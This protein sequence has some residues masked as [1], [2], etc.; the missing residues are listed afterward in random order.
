MLRNILCHIMLAAAT[1]A[2]AAD[3]TTYLTPSRG[4]A[5]VTTETALS[6]DPDLCY[7]L[8]PAETTTL[9]V[10]VGAYE[11]KPAWAGEDTKALRYRLVTEDPVG[12]LSNFF[13]LERD[14]QYVGLRNMVYNSSLFQTHDNAGYMYVLTYTEPE[15]SEWCRLTATRADGYWLFES[16]KYPIRSGNWACGYLGPWNRSVAAGE[17]IA[18]NRRNEAGDEAGRYRLF[19]ISHARLMALRSD[20]LSAATQRDFTGSIVNPSFESG[21]ERGWTLTGRESGNNEF[22]VRSDY[23]MTNKAGSYLLNAYQWWAPTLG[24]SQTVT[25]LP[26][27][28][29]E[30]SGVVATWQ[31]R[32][33]TFGANGIVA[34]VSGQGDA[35]GIRTSVRVTLGT[36]QP[37]NISAQATGQWWVSGH[38][39]E[40][41]TFFKLDDVRLTLSSLTL[42]AVAAPLPHGGRTHL[43]P[44]QWYY[45]DLPCHSEYRLVGNIEG[46]VVATDGTTTPGTGAT[47]AATYR[48]TLPGGR[49][50][51]RTTRT[52]A[53]LR[54][55]A[56]RTFVQGSFTATALNVDGLPNTIAT[57]DLN[58]DG[59]GA[60]GTK[61]IS[62]Y[63]ASKSYDIIGCSEDFNYNGSLM[64]SLTDRYDCGTVRATLSVGDLPWSQIIQGKF[65]FD[66]D[67]LNLIWRRDAVGIS[68]E[69]WTQWETMAETEGNQYVKKGFRHYDMSVGGGTVDVYILHMDAG[70]TDATWSREAQWRQLADAINAADATRPKLIIG[71][72]NSRWTREDIAANFMQRL[73]SGLTAHDVWVEFFRNGICP[74]TD[75]ADLTDASDPTA[76]ANYEIVDKIIYVNPTAANTMQLTPQTFAIEQDYTYGNVDGTDDTTPLGDH[77]PVVVTF[78]YTVPGDPTTMDIALDNDAAD[79][80]HMVAAAAGLNTNAVLT[81][82]T[83]YK[84]G[85]WNTLCL[86]FDVTLNA[87]CLGGDGVEARTLATATMT[88]THVDMVF[89]DKVERLT[90]GVPYII[91]WT[92]G[93]DIVSPTFEGVSIS[94]TTPTAISAADGHV[95]FIGYYDTFGITAAD[96]GIY[97]LT[98]AGTLTHTAVDRTLK[99][100]RAYFAFTPADAATDVK[101]LTFAIHSGDTTVGLDGAWQRSDATPG[102]SATPHIFTLS[103]QRV[104]RAVKPGLYVSGGRKVAVAGATVR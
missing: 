17:A 26:A 35:T 28:T 102:G 66:T 41:Q 45:C 104:A 99:A 68:N 100:C 60:D 2:A 7:I 32:T 69:S 14:G 11:A 61:K 22:A 92:G 57:V 94:A 15:M 71:D 63:L 4:F 73:G 84:D 42:D 8:C 48:M 79:N 5:E 20:V 91:R 75:M 72:T 47:T 13:T 86:P 97:Y 67:G 80:T 36:G 101:A 49:A 82:R 9:I 90:A 50:Y 1:V 88:S 23:G 64:E 81:G 34:T 3:Y 43:A 54:V 62:R 25:G 30:L 85:S 21:D 93:D 76:Y 77:H 24:A 74:T 39:G 87:S 40:T 95:R 44:G 31:G 70:D 56:E 58:P 10:G 103:G 52:D 96:E 38:D 6:A 83:L 51:F 59:P 89:G 53:T 46:L 78:A 37:L 19:A 18:L 27:G 65:R 16:G 33:A 98:A 55:V 12:D 29:Y